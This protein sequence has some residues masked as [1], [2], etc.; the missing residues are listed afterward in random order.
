MPAI[1]NCGRGAGAARTLLARVAI[2]IVDNFIV[3]VESKERAKPLNNSISSED[4]SWVGRVISFEKE[5]EMN[6]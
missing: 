6:G 5:K 2:L 3:F 4:W 1:E